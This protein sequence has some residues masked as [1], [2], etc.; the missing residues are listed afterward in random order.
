M[1]YYG[2]ILFCDGD[3]VVLFLDVVGLLFVCG[4]LVL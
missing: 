3:G 1:V 2:V 4:V